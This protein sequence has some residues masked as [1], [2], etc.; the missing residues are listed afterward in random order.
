MASFCEVG[1]ETRCVKTAA[2]SARD[3]VEEAVIDADEDAHGGAGVGVEQ[4]DELVGA[5]VERL[6]VEL[7]S[8]EEGE[9]VG[10]GL[11][12]G[13]EGEDAFGGD[14]VL[15]EHV[16]GEI[17]AAAVGIFLD[18]A[19]DVGELEGDAGVDGELVGAAVGVAEDA[20]ADEADD[21]G[22]E[23]AVV[24]ERGEVVVDLEGARRAGGAG[25]FDGVDAFGLGLEVEGGAGD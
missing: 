18:V 7:E 8:A 11:A 9:L 1:T 14:G 23:I 17:D 20:D 10:A 15:A 24:I 25:D 4:R 22:Y 2:G 12:A 16:G 3:A 21:R 13:G 19:K 6:G 5:A